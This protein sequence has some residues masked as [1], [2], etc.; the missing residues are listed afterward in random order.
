MSN[1][2]V[3]ECLAL[4]HMWGAEQAEQAEAPVDEELS[5]VKNFE[6]VV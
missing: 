3:M 1:D 4:L 5:L 6:H 2:M